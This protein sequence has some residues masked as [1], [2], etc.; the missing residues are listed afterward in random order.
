MP[1]LPK[2]P[3]PPFAFDPECMARRM[4]Q[5]DSRWRLKQM[6]SNTFKFTFADCDAQIS[7]ADLLGA[8]LWVV[9]AI[10]RQASEEMCWIDVELERLEDSLEEAEK[11]DDSRASAATK[12]LVYNLERSIRAI[13]STKKIASSFYHLAGDIQEQVLCK[14]V[15]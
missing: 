8:D 4:E 11:L 6:G 5:L 14:E 2:A 12:A 3:K 15:S 1:K 10:R 13:K 7:Q 9:Q